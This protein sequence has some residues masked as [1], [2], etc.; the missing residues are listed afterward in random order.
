MGVGSAGRIR[1]KDPNEARKAMGALFTEEMISAPAK[2]GSFTL[3]L[4]GRDE[5][6]RLGS[7][8]HEK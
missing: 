3:S 6:E 8:Q 2:L 7:R 5:E 1:N 4:A